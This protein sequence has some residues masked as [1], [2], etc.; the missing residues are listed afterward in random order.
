M[1]QYYEISD[2][3]KSAQIKCAK[4]NQINVTADVLTSAV[5]SKNKLQ[6]PPVKILV[7]SLHIKHYYGLIAALYRT[8]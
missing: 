6:F 3:Y 1:V 5:K 2:G 4:T 8:I 7:L